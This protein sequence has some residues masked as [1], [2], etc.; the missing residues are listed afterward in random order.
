MER[1]ADGFFE[2]KAA[3]QSGELYSFEL[4]NGQH[5]PDPASRFQPEGVHGPSQLVDDRQYQWECKS[6]AGTATANL[7]I[8][9]LH[10]GTFTK[11]GTYEGAIARLDELVALG[12]NAIELMPLAQAAGRR[13]W[14]YD[15]VNLFAPNHHYGTAD[16]LRQLVDAAHQ[17]G[18]SVIHDVIYNHFGAEGNYLHEFGGYISKHHK[19]PWGDAP[20]FDEAPCRPAR[21]WILANA[22]YWL[23]SFQMDGLRL[24]A[25]H[26]M[27]DTSSPHIVTEIGQTFADLRSTANRPYHLIA[28]SNIYDEELIKDVSTSGDTGHGFDAIWCDD[29]LHS[30]SAIVRPGEHMSCRQ[31]DPKDDLHT[32]LQRGYL[33][34]GSLHAEPQRVPLEADPQSVALEKLVVSIQ[35]HDFIGNHP[36]G[37]RFHQHSS[38]ELHRAAAALML[39][40]PAIPML[41]MGEEFA[42]DSPFYFFSDFNDGHLRTAVEEGRRREYP[43]HD[44]SNSP[45]PL[46]VAAVNKSRIG[47]ASEGDLQTRLWYRQLI[48]LRQSWQ[49]QN[50]LTSANL[51]ASWAAEDSLAK[52][53]YQLGEQEAV[54][55]VRL[56]PADAN[57]EDLTVAFDGAVLLKQ[58]GS[59]VS[60]HAGQWSLGPAGV[61]IG[62]QAA[63]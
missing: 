8:Y 21:D 49:T 17:R 60:G 19:T 35:N 33:F 34:A 32:L 27:G 48:Q 16:Q 13:N 58:N 30:V 40:Y 12:I 43:Q 57:I 55:M 62:I 37:L 4:P 29:F 9:E 46:S 7:V 45:S 53:T 18:L 51:K 22:I 23:E 63:R 61:L 25:L 44:W 59:A 15:G 1:Q 31:Y 5:R 24:D 38:L 14:G 10:I 47:P 36:A 3:A 52:M 20:N 26:C 2:S 11:A 56:H 42:T 50:L 41:F 6:F 28:E 39:T 54:V